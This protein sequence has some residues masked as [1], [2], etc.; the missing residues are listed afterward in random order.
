ML[1]Q[2]LHGPAKNMAHIPEAIQQDNSAKA[3]WGKPEVML[4]SV[5]N[6]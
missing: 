3:E 4:V 2:Q 6:C 1:F 5:K